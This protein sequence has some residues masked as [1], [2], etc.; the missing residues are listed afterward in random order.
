MD[1]LLPSGQMSTVNACWF[2]NLTHSKRNK[3]LILTKEYNPVD[4]P[5]YDNYDGI[6][7]DRTKDIPKDY[8]KVIGVPVSFMD[9]YNPE[10]FEIIGTVGASG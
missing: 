4:Y 6:N 7:V 3:K 1:F 5:K 9:K 2:T 10:Q 8:Y